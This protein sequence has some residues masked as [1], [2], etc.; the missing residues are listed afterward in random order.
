[1]QR[2]NTMY[3]YTMYSTKK[4]YAGLSEYHHTVCRYIKYEGHIPSQKQLVD[5]LHRKTYMGLE[6]LW[7]V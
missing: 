2:V 1:M 7:D 3:M 4:K 6:F 5:D